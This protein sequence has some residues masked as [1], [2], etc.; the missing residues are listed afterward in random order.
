M[1]FPHLN[2]TVAIA[3]L[4]LILLLVAG[5]PISAEDFAR[6]S[7]A[8]GLLRCV[9]QIVPTEE[10]ARDRH[11]LTRKEPS[12]PELSPGADIIDLMGRGYRYDKAGNFRGAEA[13]FRSCLKRIRGSQGQ[14]GFLEGPCLTELGIV[15]TRLDKL[16]EGRKCLEEAIVAIR[17]A[18]GSRDIAM[19]GP[20]YGLAR[21]AVKKGDL[22]TAETYFRNALAIQEDVLGKYHPDLG[23]TI[24]ELTWALCRGNYNTKCK[25]AM[26]EAVE[27]HERLYGRSHPLT[28][29][30]YADMAE[31]CWMHRDF[32]RCAELYEVALPVLG[33][34]PACDDAERGRAY[35]LAAVANEGI[36]LFGKSLDYYRKAVSSCSRRKPETT[37][38]PPLSAVLKG[39]AG[40]CE[41]TGRVQEAEALRDKLRAIH[42]ETIRESH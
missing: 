30:A 5:A 31:L 29:R 40:L 8:P 12:D 1:D 25:T 10:S 26:T 20:M 14:W 9:E 17:L 37:R 32:W 21:L 33:T 39:L 38:F 34:A 3:A 6:L 16:D 13:A 19:L 42:K 2:L 11:C 15:L 4:N 7:A 23:D 36:G 41:A 35:F 18:V 27:I 24:S 22:A 28:A